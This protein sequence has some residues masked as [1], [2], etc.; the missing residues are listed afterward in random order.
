MTHFPRRAF[1]FLLAF[2]ST[3]ITNLIYAQHNPNNDKYGSQPVLIPASPEVAELSRIG[4]LGSGLFTGAS[5]VNIPLHEI[6]VGNLSVPVALAYSNNGIRVNDIPSRVGLGFNLIAGGGLSRSI[7]DEP[8]DLSIQLAPVNFQNKNDTLLDY[9]FYATTPGYDTERDIYSINAPGLS[10]RFFLDAAG[11]PRFLEHSNLKVQ[12]NGIPTIESFTVINSEGIRYYFGQLDLVETT[13]EI[14]LNGVQPKFKNQK[15]NWFLTRIESPEGDFVEFNYSAIYIKTIQ[16]ISQTVTLEPHTANT[17][18]TNCGICEPSLPVLQYDQL[19]Y[20]TFYL[21]NIVASDGTVLSFSYSPRNDTSGDNRLASISLTAGGIPIKTMSFSYEDRPAEDGVRNGKFFLKQILQ[22]SGSLPSEFIL[23]NKFDYVSQDNVP[24]QRSLSQDYMGYYNGAVN[25]TFYPRIQNSA[26]YIHAEI[27][28]D[29]KPHGAFAS[30]G[31]LKRVTFATGGY[32][33]YQYGPHTVSR[34]EPFTTWT[35][36][37]NA[38]D[39]LDRSNPKSVQLDLSPLQNQTAEFIFSVG[40]NPGGPT[41]SDPN[42][43]PPDGVRVIATLEFRKT[44]SNELLFRKTF[45]NYGTQVYPTPLVTGENYRAVITVSGQSNQA[46][47]SIKY[48]PVTTIKTFNKEACGIRV[49]SIV[50]YDP[51]KE[52]FINKYYRY[53]PQS[54]TTRST[55]VGFEGAPVVEFNTAGWCANTTNEY[56]RIYFHCSNATVYSSN[57]QPPLAYGGSNIAYGNVLESDDPKF[58][59]GSTEHSYITSSVGVPQQVIGNRITLLSN[60]DHIDFAGKETSTKYFAKQDNQLVLSKSVENFYGLDN[61]VYF[62]AP[63]YSARKRHGFSGNNPEPIEMKLLSYDLNSYTYS[64]GWIH[65]DSVITTQYNGQGNA[66]LVARQRYIYENP[67]NPVLSATTTLNSKGEIVKET[68][69]Y[70]TD[71]SD[72][73]S[74][75]MIAKNIISP[76]IERKILVNGLQT[77]IEQTSFKDW[78]SDSRVIKP[79]LLK[80]GTTGMAEDTLLHYYAYNQKGRVVSLAKEHGPRTTYIWGYRN[81]Y[82]IAEIRNIDYATLV[83]A[84]GGETNLTRWENI[85]PLD[86]DLDVFFNQLRSNSVMSPALSKTFIYSPE[87]GIRVATDEG[88]RNTYYDYDGFQRLFTIKDYKKDILKHYVYHYQLTAIPPVITY[89]NQR[90]TSEFTKNNCGTNAEGSTVVYVVAAG[91]YTSTDSQ[92]NADFKAQAELS[93]QG[94]QYANLQGICIPCSGNDK[95]MINGKCITAFKI[96]TRSTWDGTAYKCLYT[97]SWPDGSQAQGSEISNTPCVNSG[98]E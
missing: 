54:D 63:S 5:R 50:S 57:I 83:T 89:Y 74:L 15:T 10:G 95:K 3:F 20:D 24:S 43:G 40:P 41:E 97:L 48:D 9:L 27:G 36:G 79:E 45:F 69:R 13:K 29:R 47:V 19:D 12:V 72:P 7:H 18:P 28:A 26:D 11:V 25:G 62:E 64:S 65:L 68:M 90:L 93:S 6:K 82:P 31:A 49:N 14:I 38:T 86:E 44:A 37:H 46:S 59:N 55:G 96:Y 53:T 4:Q 61:R 21:N 98:I 8:D 58:L 84:V 76:V 16:G 35:N 34:T 87:I 91:K 67:S 88:G 23:I 71:Y 78:F 60:F 30:V 85:M 77:G 1:T 94:Q 81:R 2:T 75:K 80:A 92:Q 73:V 33:E 70:P 42:Y 56:G 17:P 52:N 66:P 22:S 32:D 51:V 39:G